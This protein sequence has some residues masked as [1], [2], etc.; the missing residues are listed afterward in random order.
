[1]TSGG[2][3]PRTTPMPTSLDEYES[4]HGL[5]QPVRKHVKT[6]IVRPARVSFEEVYAQYPSTKLGAEALHAAMDRDL[7]F[8]ILKDMA[9]ITTRRG[10][11]AK[12]AAAR[13]AKQAG[14]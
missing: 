8:D 6:R 9:K 4:A 3:A 13:A 1:M 7:Y 2:S 10:L 5:P 12:E 14:A 11:V